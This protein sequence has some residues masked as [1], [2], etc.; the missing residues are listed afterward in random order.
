[1]SNTC[2]ALSRK[3]WESLSHHAGLEGMSTCF[4][5]VYVWLWICI[6]SLRLP[7]G[8]WKDPIH[9]EMSKGRMAGT[10]EG[11]DDQA[12]GVGNTFASRR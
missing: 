1:M 7:R 4:M 11:G 2:G 6:W 5:I 10:T 9:I 3:G 12:H 8:S